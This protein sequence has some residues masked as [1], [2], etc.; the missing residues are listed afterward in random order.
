MSDELICGSEIA[1][2]NRIRQ[3]DAVWFLNPGGERKC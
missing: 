2:A 3:E 1:R